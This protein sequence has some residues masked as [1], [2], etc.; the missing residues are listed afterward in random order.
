[1]LLTYT[2]DHDIHRVLFQV[3]YIALAWVYGTFFLVYF[4][5]SV[6]IVVLIFLRLLWY[7]FVKP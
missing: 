4:G 6:C 1:M 5:G 2:T 3:L 7:K